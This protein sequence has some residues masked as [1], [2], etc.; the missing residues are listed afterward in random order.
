[1]LKS[2]SIV[3]LAI[4]SFAATCRLVAE[5][6]KATRPPKRESKEPMIVENFEKA[7]GKVNL[8]ADEKAKFT[9][10]KKE[11]D[12]KFKAAQMK[13]HGNLTEE[14][15]KAGEAAIKEAKAAGKKWREAMEA[16]NAAM[17]LTEE[18]KTAIKD[19]RKELEAL[20]KEFREKVMSLLTPEQREELKKS[21]GGPRA[22]GKAK[23][24]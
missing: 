2:S 5:E 18:Q 3:L 13:V 7:L 15:K 19:G 4:L 9:A 12:P 24:E 6:P 1:M 17:K 20:R 10:L 23:P 22:R 14:Q 11:Y 21:L 8:T 16:A